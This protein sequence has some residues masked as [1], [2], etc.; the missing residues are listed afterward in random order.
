[1]PRL[2]CAVIATLVAAL[3]AAQA[4]DPPRR[5]ESQQEYWA[6]VDRKDWSAA[7]AAGEQ[8]VAAARAQTP[9]EPAGG[10]AVAPR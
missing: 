6:Q 7:I 10:G 9:Q 3:P 4:A 5:P 8:L 2:F 1:M